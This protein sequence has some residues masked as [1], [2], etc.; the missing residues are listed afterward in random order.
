LPL[1]L[2]FQKDN[3]RVSRQFIITFFTYFILLI[4]LFPNN[5]IHKYFKGGDIIVEGEAAFM[6][7]DSTQDSE[8][9]Q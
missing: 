5:P 9:H 8:A 1:I 2:I 6:L 4:T 3:F 7:N